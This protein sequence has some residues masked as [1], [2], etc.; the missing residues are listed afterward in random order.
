MKRLAI[1]LTVILF[2]LTGNTAIEGHAAAA[3]SGIGPSNP[4]KKWTLDMN[5][6]DPVVFGNDGTI[7]S[8]GEGLNAISPSGQVLWYFDLPNVN[9]HSTKPAIG[10]DG[11]IYISF[12]GF[13]GDPHNDLAAVNPDGTLKWTYSSTTRLTAPAV[14]PDGTVYVQSG[15]ELAALNPDG[16]V[17]WSIDHGNIYEFKT[18]PVFSSDGTVYIGTDGDG[19]TAIAPDGTVKWNNPKTG[20]APYVGADGTIYAYDSWGDINLIAPDG[21]EKRRIQYREPGF[22]P[23][24]PVFTVAKDGS[25]YIG[26]GDQMKAYDAEGKLKWTFI[27]A[28]GVTFLD[29]GRAELSRPVIGPDGTIYFGS[30]DEHVYAVDAAGK[31]KWMYFAGTGA[32]FHYGQ[33]WD[34]SYFELGIIPSVA[35]GPD[36]TLYVSSEELVMADEQHPGN[37]VGGYPRQ[38]IALGDQGGTPPNPRII[39]EP[40]YV[41]ATTG[42]FLVG[43]VDHSK[44]LIANAKIEVINEAGEVAATGVTD[45]GGNASFTLEKEG[46]YTIRASQEGYEASS[47]QARLLLGQSR[48]VG[49]MMKEIFTGPLFGVLVTDPSS[50]AAISDVKVTIVF[51]DTGAEFTS[52]SDSTGSATFYNLPD[53]GEFSVKVEKQ[54]F[55]SHSDGPYS[56]KYFPLFVD[57][58]LVAPSI[59]IKVVD[60]DGNPV[61]YAQLYNLDVG[62]VGP[63][64]DENGI[65]TVTNVPSGTSLTIQASNYGLTEQTTANLK[66]TD[67]KREFTIVIGAKNTSVETPTST[68]PGQ[69]AQGAGATSGA[70]NTVFI[71]GKAQNFGTSPIQINGMTFVPMRGIFEALHATVKWDQATKKITAFRGTTTI[72]LTLGSKKALI[73]GQQATLQQASFA[74]NGTTFVPLRFISEALKASVK[75]DAKTGNIDITSP[76]N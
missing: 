58:M 55:V 15:K 6:R 47:V 72:S 52:V 66:V 75:W 57:E 13:T 19:L 45:A 37:I 46:L 42:K 1:M 53:D 56:S 16:T 27:T 43:V 71:N 59:T 30:Y 21:T 40:S 17:K 31:L 69:P 61:R 36:G 26:D 49:I 25:V 29:K 18:M 9:Y 35:L 10:R 68:T 48:G 20:D 7:Y 5:S 14:S 73:N 28:E 4:I 60:G 39:P 51:T 3:S 41:T 38:L 12:N 70:R 62:M 8:G 63:Q 64:V 11:T 32:V 67:T 44:Y 33:V 50:K 54:G 23:L 2:W 76:V 34:H 74:K 24:A 22:G 65:A